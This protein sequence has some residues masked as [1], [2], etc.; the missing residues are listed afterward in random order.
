[1]DPSSREET[2]MMGAARKR[3]M[4][5]RGGTGIHA[6]RLRRSRAVLAPDRAGWGAGISRVRASFR[7]LVL[8]AWKGMRLLFA[9]GCVVLIVLWARR[10]GF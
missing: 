2:M 8:L 9:L 10:S 5:L 7:P 4:P 3:A 6:A 1:M